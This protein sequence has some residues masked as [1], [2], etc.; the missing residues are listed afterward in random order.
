LVLIA[1][2][3]GYS[4]YQT[5]IENPWT[6]DGHVRAYVIQITP[7]VTGQLTHIA[8]KDNARVKKGDLLFQIDASIYE[9]DLAKAIA[10]E[11]Q[12]QALLNRAKNEERRGKELQRLDTGAIPELTMNNL[13]NAVESA[14][15][16][17]ALSKAVVEEAKLNLQFTD[18]YAPTDGY[19]SNLNVR[20][21]SQV[22]ANSPVVALI[23]ENSFWIEGF[24]KETDLQGVD[25]GDDAYV[26]LLTNTDAILHGKV[27]SLGF[28]IS[29]A[30]GSRGNN[31]LANVNPNFQWVRLA[32]RIPVKIKLTDLPKDQQLRVGMTASIKIIKG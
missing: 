17:L 1:F 24:F 2:M 31:L 30:D 19:I 11:K 6:R 14:A 12:A 20:V 21:G 27:K 8:V 3:V 16:Q 5:Y 26:T 22:T 28:G 23:D 10:S 32:Q 7:R 4:H 25:A 29:M 15:A 9:A 13:T 18:V